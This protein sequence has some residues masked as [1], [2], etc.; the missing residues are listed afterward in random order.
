[1]VIEPVI[2]FTYIMTF[3]VGLIIGSFLNVCIYRI[4]SE[5]LS[6]HYPRHSFCPSCGNTI[7]V[8]DNIPILSYFI[9]GGKCRYC[10]SKISI[11]YPLVEFLTGAFFLLLLYTFQ[12]SLTFV[13]ACIFV[14][15]LIAISAIDL[16]HFI[17]PNELV[18]TGMII[19]LIF[20]I[21]TAVIN[22]KP[23]YV[24]YGIIGMFSGGGIILAVGWFGKLLLRREAMGM[25]DVKLMAM[26]GMY[27]SWWPYQQATSLEYLLRS[28]RLLMIV[29]FISAFVGA[30][31]GT[32]AMLF[33]KGE[34]RN[35][36]PYGPF[37]AAAA[38]LTL[39]YG[40]KIWTWYL[41]FLS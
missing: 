18:Y 32:I 34:S 3:I 10:K 14:S 9:L 36:I 31:I 37:L 17:I 38:V 2:L 7:R 22:H 8:Y 11:Q 19:G 30:I 24:I 26:I 23:I 33:R 35:V 40:E 1:M 5:G 41:G 28:I 15:T 12:L 6:I 39:L 21:I 29:L 16:K 13:V 25:G 27:L 20:A 4:P